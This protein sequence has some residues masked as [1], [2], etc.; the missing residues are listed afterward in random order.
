MNSARLLHVLAMCTV[1]YVS[2]GP[3]QVV[4]VLLWN[5]T[6]K[7][8]VCISE[9]ISHN[10]NSRNSRDCQSK[11]F[12]VSSRLET[13]EKVAVSKSGICWQESFFGGL[14]TLWKV[15]FFTQSLLI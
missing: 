1:S 6:S 7:M 15:I 9:V 4:V 10:I 5:R 8:R 13:P 3:E 11:V 14:P 12:R 2:L